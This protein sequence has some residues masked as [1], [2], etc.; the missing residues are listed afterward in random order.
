MNIKEWVQDHPKGV[1]FKCDCGATVNLQIRVENFRLVFYARCWKCNK[2]MTFYEHTMIVDSA[3]FDIIDYLIE[4][5]KKEFNKNEK[6][7]I[8]RVVK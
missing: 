8:V 7:K 4:N 1:T 3:M 5:F 6:P 2:E